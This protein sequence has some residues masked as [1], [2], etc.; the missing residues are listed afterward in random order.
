MT[1]DVRKGQTDMPYQGEHQTLTNQNM[2][3]HVYPA[4][5]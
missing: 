2:R 3:Y 4:E 1:A 5:I